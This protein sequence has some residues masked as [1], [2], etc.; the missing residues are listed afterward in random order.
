MKFASFKYERPQLDQVKEQFY[1]AIHQIKEATSHEALKE[2]IQAVRHIQNNL[3]TQGTLC[4]IRHSID[5]KDD[6]YSQET[7]FWDEHYPL[8]ANWEKDYYQAVLENELSQSLKGDFLPEPFFAI[9]ENQLRTNSEAVIPLLQEEN[10]LVSEY[11]KLK[12][13]AEIEFK[14]QVYNLSSIGAFT[15]SADRLERKEAFEKISAWYQKHQDD[16]DRIYDQMVKVRHEIAKKLGFKDF[17]EL[18]YARMLRLDYD[19]QDV[20]RYR[21]EVIKYVVPLAE[22]LVQAQKERLNLDHL[23]YYDLGL[24]FP[25]GNANPSGTSQEIVDKAQTMYH[26]LSKETGEYFDFMR[27]GDLLDLESKPGKDTGG[28]CT[29]LPNYKAPFIFANFN[30]TSHDVEVLTHEAGHG[31]QVYSSMWIETPEVV[32]PTYETCEIHSMSME[33]LTWP[34]MENFFQEST[35]KFKY[36]HLAGALMFIPYGCLV[37]HFQHEVYEHPEWIPQE[38]RQA[39]RRLE[40]IY[41][42][43]IDYEGNDFYEQGGLW[44]KQLHIF[45][46]PFYYIDYTLAQVCAFQFWKRDH[47]DHDP[48]TWEDYVRIC[49]LGGTKTFTQV[50]AAANLKSPFEPGNLEETVASID[51]YLSAVDPQAL[52]K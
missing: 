32:W 49:R 3:A 41:N 40:K 28:Y 42:P 31:F 46:M 23:A 48:K 50:V 12:A 35:T 25:K 2:A 1:Q 15:Q 9:A 36:Q 17:V 20:E 43:W 33:F 16:F 21:Q 47:V 13:S 24:M 30:G 29:H 34:W 8:I 6:F 38:R 44:F 18:G 27:S 37:D 45:T 4:S 5:T 11:G 22:K 19:R 39:F 52:L 51:Q 14:G 26:E 10:R 7:D